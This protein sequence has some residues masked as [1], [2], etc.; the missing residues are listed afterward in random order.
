MPEDET[1]PTA[2][3]LQQYFTLLEQINSNSKDLLNSPEYRI[4]LS[5]ESTINERKL[6]GAEILKTMNKLYRMLIHDLKDEV[7]GSIANEN[8]APIGTISE[9]KNDINI[10]IKEAEI[11]DDDSVLD[12]IFDFHFLQME[13]INTE[14]PKKLLHLMKLLSKRIKES[15]KDEY[16]DLVLNIKEESKK[17]NELRQISFILYKLL[18]YLF[19]SKENNMLV[20]FNRNILFIILWFRLKQFTHQRLWLLIKNKLNDFPL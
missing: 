18:K 6:E 11:E 4:L 14:L 3:L 2:E 8:K 15:I 1:Y 16:G 20:K 19:L 7:K 5:L 9:M 10:T 17:M 13:D 12:F